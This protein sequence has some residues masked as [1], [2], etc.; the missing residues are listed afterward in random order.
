ME[1]NIPESHESLQQDAFFVSEPVDS[2]DRVISAKSL[3]DIVPRTEQ[4]ESVPDGEPNGESTAETSNEI[5][6]PLS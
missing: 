6:E 1:N 3:D 2:M 5:D 4:L